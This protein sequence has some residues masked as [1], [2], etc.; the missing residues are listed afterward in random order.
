MLP[1][2]PEGASPSGI[3]LPLIPRGRNDLSENRNELE[4]F[5]FNIFE[6]GIQKPLYLTETIKRH[7]FIFHLK[8]SN[9]TIPAHFT[10]RQGSCQNTENRC[11]KGNWT[12]SAGFSASV[13]FD[14][15]CWDNSFSSVLKNS[16]IFSNLP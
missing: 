6:K 5:G 2:I 10:H 16:I 9:F 12:P 14:M 8:S 13:I 1:K 11:R 7:R 4:S 15:S 3:C